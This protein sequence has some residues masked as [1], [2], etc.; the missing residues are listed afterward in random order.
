[1][2]VHS[3]ASYFSVTK[4]RSRTGSYHYLI[5]S[6]KE[7]PDN[8]PIKNVCKTM[9]YAMVS[10]EETEIGAYF[11]NAQDAVPERT[12]LIEMGHPHPPTRTHM[13]NTTE[14]EFYNQTLNQ[15]RF[16]SIGMRF[17][18]MQDR[19]SQRQFLFEIRSN[20]TW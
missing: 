19:C 11:I 5:N 6:S 10:A 18:W 12:T 13:D 14:D 3:D 7:P 15:N 2:R 9:T 17:Y 16:K 8:G 20:Q 4:A 1:M